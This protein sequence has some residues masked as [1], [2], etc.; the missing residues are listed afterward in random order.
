MSDEGS[1]MKK[2]AETRREGDA[3]RRYLGVSV[4]VRLSLCWI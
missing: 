3:E 4:P 1:G 2:D